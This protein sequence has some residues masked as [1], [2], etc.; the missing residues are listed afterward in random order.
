MM[1]PDF[2]I[3]CRKTSMK[4]SPGK[5]IKFAVMTSFVSVLVYV[6]AVDASSAESS[7]TPV[8]LGM[9]VKT[10]CMLSSLA[11]MVSVYVN[12]SGTVTSI[13]SK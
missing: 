5:V 8:G 7:L 1:D 4:D 3:N 9:Y 12:P 6:V 11:F 13:G 10:E 2:L